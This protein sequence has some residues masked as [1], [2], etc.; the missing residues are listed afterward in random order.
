M[1]TTLLK[2]LVAALAACGA[3][4]SI[5]GW[6]RQTVELDGIPGF[7]PAISTATSLA[8]IPLL[9]QRAI[10]VFDGVKA[11]RLELD[12]R[13][14][15][16][17]YSAAT[18]RL[19]VLGMFDNAV[20]AIDEAS[21][22]RTRIGVGSF[23]DNVIVDDARGKVYVSNWGG[24]IGEGSL[25]II[26][27]GTLAVRNVPLRGPASSFVQDS[28]T[29]ALFVV[30]GSIAGHST[31][32]ALDAEGNVTAREGLRYQGYSLAVDSRTGHVYS[33]AL[34][35]RPSLD[36]DTVV[37]IF[38]VYAQPG[39]QLVTRHDWPAGRDFFK[40]NFMID[41]ARPGIYFSSGQNT[42]LFRLNAAGQDLEMWHLPLGST[43]LYDGRTV[44]NGIFGLDTDPAS[45]NLFISS[46]TGSLLMEVDIRTGATEVVGIPGAVGFSGVHFWP[47]GRVMVTDGSG[48][49]QL[50]L[51]KRSPPAE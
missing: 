23:P 50:T 40:L 43:T 18:G 2:L 4:L 12:I 8:Y 10:S 19:F 46:P 25:S 20:I 31:L 48:D 37:R 51:L 44:V 33:G 15:A 5:A 26:D 35:H 38:R 32:V 24:V 34:S 49:F 45:G 6:E 27:S 21:G 39:L 14:T 3:G 9:Q 30:V 13:P 29:G 22:A 16:V 11:T 42:T 17:A 7:K 28:A 41:A 36:P 1:R 47:D